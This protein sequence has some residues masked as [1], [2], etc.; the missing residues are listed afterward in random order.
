MSGA[1]SENIGYNSLSGPQGLESPSEQIYVLTSSQLEQI[2]ER[3]V[4]RAQA[5][6]LERIE[7]LESRRDALEEGVGCKEG[8]EPWPQGGQDQERSLPDGQGMQISTFR[9]VHNLQLENSALKSE[10][11]GLQEATARERA[12][13]RQRIAKL[14][15][16][17]LHNHRDS[18]PAPGTKTEARIKAIKEVLK[19]RGS[20]TFKELER[21]LG[22]SSREM[23]RLTKKLDMRQYEIFRRQGDTREKVIRLRAQISN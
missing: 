20:T 3:A 8:E 4:A 5:P 21:I 12:F 7:R 13:D 1:I 19:T 10:L 6:L 15:H 22:I 14:E 2:I 18:A 11:E 17:D 9:I 16:G 23:L